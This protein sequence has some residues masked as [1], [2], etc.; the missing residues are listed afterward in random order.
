[1]GVLTAKKPILNNFRLNPTVNMKQGVMNNTFSISTIRSTYLSSF[2]RALKNLEL[3]V[4][5][6]KTT[7]ESRKIRKAFAQNIR[8]KA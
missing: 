2:D 3:Y 5:E 7:I 6:E 4:S 8:A 1:M